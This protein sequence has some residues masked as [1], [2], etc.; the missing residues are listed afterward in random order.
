MLLSG[1]VHLGTKVRGQEYN[2]QGKRDPF[3]D[4]EESRKEKAPKILEPPPLTQRPP[5]LAGLLISEVTVAGS[6]SNS[7]MHL[8]ILK[9]IDEFTYF[10]R[11]GSKLF[12]GYLE[13]ISDDKMIFTREVVDTKGKK[14]TTK[15]VKEVE[16]AVLRK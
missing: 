12:D 4:L 8:V 13:E 6:A 10:A 14:R 2:S 7:K 3:L 15:I 9:G 5:G 16:R 11:V 1:I